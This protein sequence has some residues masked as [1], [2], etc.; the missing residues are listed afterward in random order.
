MNI[1][2]FRLSRPG[3]FTQDLERQKKIHRAVGMTD[4]PLF[5]GGAI[6]ACHKLRIA[7]WDVLTPYKLST[8]KAGKVQILTFSYVTASFYVCGLLLK[9]T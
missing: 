3:R 5:R 2:V 1:S 7:L 4:M 9:A 8:H 6:H